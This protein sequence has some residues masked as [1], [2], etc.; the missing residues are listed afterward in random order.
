MESPPPPLA[1]EAS[2]KPVPASSHTGPQILIVVV[3]VAAIVG[4][5]V[6]L[7]KLIDKPP[8]PN[9][10]ENAC[11]AGTFV[12][13]IGAKDADTVGEHLSDMRQQQSIKTTRNTFLFAPAASSAQAVFEP[14]SDD[15]GRW[16]YC[17]CVDPSSFRIVGTG[18]L[19]ENPVTVA[20][21]ADVY[22]SG[23][24]YVTTVPESKAYSWGNSDKPEIGSIPVCACEKDYGFEN[25]DTFY[26]C[27]P[28]YGGHCSME[29]DPRLEICPSQELPNNDEGQYMYCC[30]KDC[31]NK[32]YDPVQNACT[33]CPPD[34]LCRPSH[35]G[36]L[37]S[38]S[39]FS[40]VELSRPNDECECNENF[41]KL[42]PQD[43]GAAGVVVTNPDGSTP[44]TPGLPAQLR[45]VAN[46]A[47]YTG[48]TSLC[49]KGI[50]WNGTQ[51]QCVCDCDG[52]L[53][54][55]FDL[56]NGTCCEGAS[57]CQATSC[58]TQEQFQQ[59]SQKQ[60]LGYCQSHCKE[61]HSFCTPP[62]CCPQ[63]K[64]QNG[65]CVVKSSTEGEETLPDTINLPVA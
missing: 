48:D 57:N 18:Q 30:C 41:T 15:T 56:T 6:T 35:N 17:S 61:P 33:K 14:G 12:E 21:C 47:A 64:V 40:Y 63:C 53:Q 4:I 28:L 36:D 43:V 60:K 32:C 44:W 65:N 49:L 55:N 25:V 39:S 46:T 19:C 7:W 9:P 2:L 27:A 62:D 8:P 11:S 31:P 13:V 58:V 20:S 34:I 37:G 45:C 52:D 3:A 42:N 54:F 16:G 1:T 51:Y 29:D 22:D 50:A 5:V 23:A 10:L 26:S 38:A 24:K 59:M